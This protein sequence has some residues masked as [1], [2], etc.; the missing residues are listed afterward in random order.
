M[1]VY[2][3]QINA[4]G[5]MVQ[6]PYQ[7]ALAHN[8]SIS[9]LPSGLRKRWGWRASGMTGFS[10]R[11]LGRWELNYTAINDAELA[12][13]RTF[14]DS[15]RGRLGEFTYIDP[16]GNLVPHSEDFNYTG[17]S[18]PGAG[19]ATTDP[20][21]GTRARSVG[22]GTFSCVV[23]PAGGA[24]GFVFCVSAWIKA[25]SST[26]ATLSLTGAGSTVTQLPAGVWIRASH[27]GAV[28]SGAV[29]ASL[30]L[31]GGG[32]MFGAQVAPLPGPGGYSAA[33][34]NPGLHPKCRFDIDKLMPRYVGPNQIELK[35][36]VVE[37]F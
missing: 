36:S 37:Y 15:M 31:A 5:V 20:F 11:A 29:S 30:A 23:L 13:L 6:R 22:A 14:F 28:G 12:V 10:S 33:P 26:T 34:G 7:A 17:W 32:V 16:A 24:G 9:E 3:P 35:L 2:F 25:S 18:G 4:G 27:A 1:P 21:G 8:S 19:G